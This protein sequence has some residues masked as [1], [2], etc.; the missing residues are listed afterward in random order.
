MKNDVVLVRDYVVGDEEHYGL[1]Q[2]CEISPEIFLAN[3]SREGRRPLLRN[4][5]GTGVNKPPLQHPA[6]QQYYS[7]EIMMRLENGA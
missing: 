2:I 6:T 4:R 3:L 5:P 1:L 7:T